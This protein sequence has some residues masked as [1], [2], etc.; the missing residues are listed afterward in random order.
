MLR[1]LLPLAAGAICAATSAIACPDP[2]E[3]G[4]QFSFTG[5]EL[6]NR[7]SFPVVAGGGNSIQSCPIRFLTDR[8]PGYV[9]RS[10]DFTF[11]IAGLQRYELVF[12]VESNCDNILVLNTGMGAWF[13]DD[14][15]GGGHDASIHLTRP[16]D[17]LF[18]IWIGTFEEGRDC[19]ATLYVE[20]FDK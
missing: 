6:Y 20:T 15:D 10:P 13:Y 9:T 14:D 17:G 11:D 8:G 5:N 3:W 7:H 18:D 16:K 12:D 19:D 2:T 4:D 1:L